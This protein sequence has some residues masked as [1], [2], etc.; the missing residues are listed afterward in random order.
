MAVTTLDPTTALVVIDLQRGTSVNPFFSPFG[1]V[2]ANAAELAT[3]FRSAGLPVVQVNFLPDR[4]SGRAEYGRP[5]VAPPAEFAQFVPELGVTETDVV[6]T[7][8]GW[9]AFAGTDLHSR[10][11]GLGVTQVVL[12]GVATSFGVESTARQAHELGYNVTLAIDAM[13][14]IS[15]EA[16]QNSVSRI[17][18]ILGETGSTRDIAALLAS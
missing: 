7:K 13:T 2:V 18:P 12:A 4:A 11:T 17:F 5:F 9:G 10:L 16:H 1:D 14:D 15:P 6:V 8:T 3:A